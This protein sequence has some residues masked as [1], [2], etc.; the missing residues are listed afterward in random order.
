MPLPPALLARLQKR[1]IVNEQTTTPAPAA[2]TKT[3]AG[4]EVEEVFAEDYDEPVKDSE[5][6]PETAALTV[7]NGDKPKDEEEEDEDTDM[8]E[9]IACPNKTNPYHTCSDYCKNRYGMKKWNPDPDMIRK[10]DRMLRKYP[11]PPDWQEVADPETDRYFYWNTLTDQVSWLSPLHP[12]ADVTISAEKLLSVLRSKEEAMV[13]SE[14]EDEEDMEVNADADASD[15][16]DSSSSSSSSEDEEEYDRRNIRGRG[17]S[18]SG[19]DRGRGRGGGGSRG[20]KEELDPMDPA[21]YSDVPRG[22]WS[23]GLERQG[24]A[25]TGVDTTASGPLF[26]QRPYPSPGAVLRAN[27]A[28]KPP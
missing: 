5:P 16:S 22:G 15:M 25:K 8:R 1:G 26:Q 18:D 21:S 4:E 6:E 19:R 10:R 9:V 14:S 3:P 23:S 28:S 12:N 13:E 24:E 17:S 27:K 7:V 20:R 2:A 11:L